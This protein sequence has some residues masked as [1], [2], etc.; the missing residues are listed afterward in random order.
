MV[1]LRLKARLG[2]SDPHEACVGAR[3]E[4]LSLARAFATSFSSAPLMSP[5]LEFAI[6]RV[7]D[8]LIER[9]ADIFTPGLRSPPFCQ[10]RKSRFSFVRSI[11]PRN[12]AERPKIFR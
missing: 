7:S 10:L 5:T 6:T 8:H 12:L 1:F 3:G 9:A 2:A 4:V 11:H